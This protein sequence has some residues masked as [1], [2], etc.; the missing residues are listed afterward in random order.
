MRRK[1]QSDLTQRFITARIKVVRARVCARIELATEE[2]SASQFKGSPLLKTAGKEAR[3][4][5]DLYLTRDK[6]QLSDGYRRRKSV[7]TLEEAAMFEPV[8]A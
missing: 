6:S 4:S 3:F 2:S 7:L 8:A 5:G 1:D